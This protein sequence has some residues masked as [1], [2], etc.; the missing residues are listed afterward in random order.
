MLNRTAEP[1]R[2]HVSFACLLGTGSPK[3][4]YEEKEVEEPRKEKR[5]SVPQE[6]AI[7]PQGSFLGLKLLSNSEVTL[8][9]RPGLISGCSE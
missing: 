6:L 5:L 3:L 2:P 7:A 4:L 8:F 1:S 9:S